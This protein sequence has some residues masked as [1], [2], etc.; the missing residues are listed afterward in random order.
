MAV[1]QNKDELV[2]AING[3]FDKLR[4]QFTRVPQAI[5]H[6]KTMDGHVKETT[7]SVADL[8]AYLVGWNELV[9]KW[10]EQD[11][12][13]IDVDF[14]ETGFKWNELGKLAQKFYR[15]YECVPYPQLLERLNSAKER[16]VLLI[17]SRSDDELYGR[18]W[19]EKWTMGR[20]IQ[21]NTS[22]PYENARGRLRKWFKTEA[23]GH[24]MIVQPM[25]FW[26]NDSTI[27][28]TFGACA[29]AG[30]YS[31]FSPPISSGISRRKLCPF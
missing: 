5:V 18:S 26:L 3:N 6:D 24:R 30:H 16:I 20:M 12:A 10:L 31:S 13:G 2:K 14:P 9:L 11:A 17:E 25:Q 7:M 28:P 27:P 4:Q 22:S 23:T 29:F 21:F 8:V 1:L 19:Y 15:D